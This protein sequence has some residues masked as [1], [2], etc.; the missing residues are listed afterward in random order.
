MVAATAGR[1]FWILDDVGAIQNSFD[2][3]ERLKIIQ[4]KPSYRIFGGSQDKPIPGLGQNPKSGVT[5]DYYLPNKLDSTELKLE[6]LSKGEV[7]RSYTNQKQKNFKSWPGGP[8]KPAVLPSKKGY[9]RFTWDFKTEALPSI[10][11]VFVFGNSNGHSVAPGTYTL[12]LTLKD[13]IVETSATVLANP[14]INAVA[15][16]YIAQQEVLSTIN[17]TVKEMHNA[18]N[19]MRSAKAQLKNYKKLLKDNE[20]AKELL[21]KGETLEKR[22]TTWEENLI[23]PKQKTFQDVIN[24]N[25][26]LN[27]DLLHLK[28]FVDVAEPKLLQ[29][30]KNVYKTY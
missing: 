30:L 1:S 28:G 25:N 12:R 18:V 6:I 3:S 19:Q 11:K 13:E 29:V 15:A 16:D 26:Q 23:Q 24:F 2:T 5:L 17:T 8:S 20:A 10:E 21:E 22:I 27:A 7:I 14:K 4:P 9:N